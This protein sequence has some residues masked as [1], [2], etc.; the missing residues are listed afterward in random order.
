VS[1]LLYFVLLMMAGTTGLAAGTAEPA[2]TSQNDFLRLEGRRD[3]PEKTQEPYSTL[4]ALLPAIHTSQGRRP[5]E[6]NGAGG[7]AGGFS[8]HVKNGKPVYECNLV[9]VARTKIAG[10]KSLAPGKNVVRAE[11]RHDG[12]GIGKGGTGTL[13]VNGKRVA[14][15]RIEHTQGII[16]SEEEGTDVGQDGETPVI[17]N[18]GI[19]A[20]YKFT[21]KIDKVT[22]DLKQMTQ[23]AVT[24]ENKRREEAAHKKAMSD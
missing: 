15:G 23:A 7:V 1:I 19:P 17:E 20:P 18:Y 13:F 16:F 10:T 3:R 14:Q 4:Q 22:T 6:R 5:A 12:G 21:G 9:G 8:L 2:K 11:F 24:E